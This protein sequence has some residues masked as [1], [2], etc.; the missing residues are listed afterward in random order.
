[1]KDR[2]IRC[3]ANP[4]CRCRKNSRIPPVVRNVECGPAGF[5]RNQGSTA[6]GNLTD[7][8]RLSGGKP[9][10]PGDSPSSAEL[11]RKRAYLKILHIGSADNLMDA[12]QVLII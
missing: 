5:F 3:V 6:A 4:H 7:T 2:N 12:V 11:E 1:M 10:S 8:G 9:T